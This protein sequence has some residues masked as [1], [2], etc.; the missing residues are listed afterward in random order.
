[1]KRIVNAAL[2]LSLAATGL[3]ACDRKPDIPFAPVDSSL[4]DPDNPTKVF[5][6]DLARVEYEYPLTREQRLALTPENLK[7]FTQ[8]EV[9]QI[10]GRLTAGPIPDGGFEGDLFFAR[11]EDLTT[12]LDEIVGGI[13][14]RIADAK[15]KTLEKVGRHLWKGKMFYR[16]EGVLRNFIEDPKALDVL[17]DDPG[18]MMTTEIDRRGWLGMFDSKSTVYLMFPAKL[19]CGQS[20]MDGRR[21]SIIVD[22][23][24]GDEIPF[25]QERPDSL[26]G[27]NGLR[28]RDEVRMVRPGFYLGR[29]YMNRIFLLNFTVYNEAHARAGEKAF[30]DGEAIEED[31]WAGEQV[32]QA[33]RR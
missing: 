27:R 6:A 2:V 31:C 3:A 8:E 33:G 24:Y 23:N 13:G 10:Y 7:S 1:M 9:D 12:R 11:G 4:V 16:D 25:Y 26:A 21:E 5:Y 28:V 18:A 32:A 22:Y 30:R 19:Y 14:G 20:L 17:I 29:A 15:I